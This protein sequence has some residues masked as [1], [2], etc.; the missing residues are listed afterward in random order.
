[1]LLS[2]L[3]FSGVKEIA[4]TGQKVIELLGTIQ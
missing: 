1:M 2:F 3:E 4:V